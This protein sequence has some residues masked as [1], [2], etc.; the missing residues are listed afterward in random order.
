MR[1]P[2]LRVIP[3][4]LP[5]RRSANGPGMIR[6]L[7]P[8]KIAFHVVEQPVTAIDQ[9]RPEEHSA[10]RTPE[11]EPVEERGP[12]DRDQPNEP[13]H[14]LTMFSSQSLPFSTLISLNSRPLAVSAPKVRRN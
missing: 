13:L 7:E 6:V 4:H 11:Q 8:G 5:V 12:P 14:G 9:Q 10:G 2:A 1:D 3:G